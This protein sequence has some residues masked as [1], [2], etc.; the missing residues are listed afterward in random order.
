[1]FK[2]YKDDLLLAIVPTITDEV[3]EK[4]STGEY[5]FDTIVNF[6]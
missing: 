2:I 5:T 6:V 4:I 3:Y 1:M